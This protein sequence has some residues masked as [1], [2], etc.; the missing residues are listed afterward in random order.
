MSKSLLSVLALGGNKGAALQAAVNQ[1]CDGAAAAV[2]HGDK[3]AFVDTAREAEGR[4]AATVA[5]RETMTQAADILGAIR[6]GA[7]W[8]PA[9][10]AAAWAQ[11]FKAPA[12][13]DILGARLATK[14]PPKA[15]AAE[16][17]AAR[18]FGAAFGAAWKAAFVL[19]VE[20]ATAAAACTRA[21]STIGAA[22]AA[23]AG[24]LVTAQA[25]AQ[26]EGA[27]DTVA[28][29]VRTIEAA[30]AQVE[31]FKLAAEAAAAQ[32]TA[33]EK[34]AEHGAAAVKAAEECAEHVKAA[35]EAATAAQ[36]AAAPATAPDE[37]QG[38][39][40]IDIGALLAQ[41]EAAEARATLAEAAAKMA[42]YR[43]EKAE[44]AQVTA[45][46]AASRAEARAEAAAADMVR[47]EA[48]ATAAE[49][50]AQVAEAA[51]CGIKLEAAQVAPA[52]ARKARKAPALQ[53]A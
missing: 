48:R 38:D 10:T 30:A 43:A 28:P 29:M 18:I 49:A 5:V 27:A 31:G 45:E 32:V 51:L 2:L 52:A 23:V 9:A 36:V 19:H 15:T 3:S 44:A 22:A 40:R 16:A 21:L 47:A 8:A 13:G 12:L 37:M 26:V 11:S 42:L 25:A 33:A 41:V 4:A 6:T 7:T 35:A 20:G 39:A 1:V 24:S 53:A 46:A 50:A 17:E 14:N 34:P